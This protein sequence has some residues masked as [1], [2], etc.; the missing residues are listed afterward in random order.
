MY[1]HVLAVYT[2]L[3]GQ[4]VLACSSSVYL[5]VWARCTCLF[6]AACTCLFWQCVLAPLKCILVPTCLKLPRKQYTW[7][8]IR[9]FALGFMFFLPL[10]AVPSHG[11]LG[12]PGFVGFVLIWGCN[13]RFLLSRG[14]PLH[15]W[16]YRCAWGYLLQV[17]P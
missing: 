5:P 12:H 4:C 2:C 13:T 14:Y 17:L 6:S 1:L 15:V 7:S 8:C 16:P 9:Q 10:Y 11:A 3:F